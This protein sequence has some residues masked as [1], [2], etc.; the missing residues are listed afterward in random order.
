MVS[1]D[2]QGKYHLKKSFLKSLGI[3]GETEDQ[4][5]LLYRYPSS[6]NTTLLRGDKRIIKLHYHDAIESGM[7]VSEA[8]LVLRNLEDIED[9]AREKL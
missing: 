3:L 9:L 8:R 6:S 5:S 4:Y 2:Y 1:E 7:N